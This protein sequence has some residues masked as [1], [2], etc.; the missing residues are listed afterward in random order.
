MDKRTLL[1]GVASFLLIAAVAVGTILFS[2]SASFNGTT[3]GKP[4]PSAPEIVLT[5]DNGISFRLSEMRGKV[6]LVFFGYTNCP[7]ECPLTMAK[8]KQTFDLLGA[9]S[10]D[11]QVLFV[12]TDPVRDGPDVL[13]RFTAQFNPAFI[14]LSGS[15]EEMQK[16]WGDYGV[17]VEDAGATHSNRVYVID[18]NGMLRLT[19]PYEMEPDAMASDVEKLLSEK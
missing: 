5:R 8:L 17:L 3:Y 2:R 13:K 16:V 4:Y 12:T 6:V 18:R 15:L 7:D 14:G 1:V 10:A 9:Q 11:A 19:F